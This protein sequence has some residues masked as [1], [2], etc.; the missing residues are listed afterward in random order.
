MEAMTTAVS[1]RAITGLLADIEIRGIV[2]RKQINKKY[3]LGAFL[4]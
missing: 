3:M 2:C 4:N 1:G